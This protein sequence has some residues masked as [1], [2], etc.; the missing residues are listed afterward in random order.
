MNGGEGVFLTTQSFKN[1]Q[2]CAIGAHQPDAGT[3]SGRGYERRRWVLISDC[4]V[5]L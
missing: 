5:E 4:R 3:L 1:T 2:A